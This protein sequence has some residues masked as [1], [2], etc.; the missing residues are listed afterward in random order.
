MKLLSLSC[1]M[2][3]AVSWAA[4]EPEIQAIIASARATVGTEAAL[5]ELVTLKVTG[6]IEPADPKL[7]GARILRIARKHSVWRCI[8]TILSR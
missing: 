1:L 3:T 8:S 6:V 4:S 5:D 2:L 7:P